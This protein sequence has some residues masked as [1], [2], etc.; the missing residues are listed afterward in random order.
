VKKRLSPLLINA[1]SAGFLCLAL[2]GIAPLAQ[3]KPQTPHFSKTD[4]DQRVKRNYHYYF[5]PSW[6]YVGA[7]PSSGSGYDSEYWYGL[8]VKVQTALAH[9]GFY[10]GPINGIIDSGSRHAI[11]AFQKTSG[12]VET[13]LV[14]PAL[15]KALRLAV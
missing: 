3:A 8:A 5:F 2:S 12:L 7:G 6:W 11:R 10:H 14:D 1:G 13:G 9:L 4:H 15:L